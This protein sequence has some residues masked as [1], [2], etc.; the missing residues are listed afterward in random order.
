M[1]FVCRHSNT[2]RLL[3]L[4][5]ALAASCC[6]GSVATS[7][8]LWE[9]VFSVVKLHKMSLT[10]P[11][12]VDKN[13]VPYIPLLEGFLHHSTPKVLRGGWERILSVPVHCLWPG[14]PEAPVGEDKETRPLPRVEWFVCL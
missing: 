12:R 4:P 2:M 5:A 13:H 10:K 3:L 6:S 9:T 14:L 7:L 11:Q 8:L 1:V